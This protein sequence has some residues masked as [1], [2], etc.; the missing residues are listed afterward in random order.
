MANRRYPIKKREFAVLT[1]G[2]FLYALLYAPGV[3]IEQ[4]G[5]VSPSATAMRFLP[6]FI[7]A[8]AAL[9]LLMQKL[10]PKCFGAAKAMPT[11]E[12]PFCAWAAFLLIL[13]C[14]IP[15]FLIYYPGTFAYDTQVQAQ[16]VVCHQYSQFH[17]LAHTLFLGACLSLFGV[18]QTLEQ[19]AAV[20]SAVQMTAMAACFALACASVS[21]S[22]SRRAARICTAVFALWPY[23]M[24]FASTCTKDVLFSGFLT[25]FFALTLEY[26][27]TGGLTKPRLALMVVGGAMACLL[28]NNMIYAMLVWVALLLVFG[29]GVRRAA[30]WAL[31][32]AVLGMGAN[33]GL[34]ALTHADSGDAKE[35]LSVPAQQLSRAYTL[36]PESL[37]EADMFA[38]DTYFGDA[39]YTRYDAT[40]ADFTKNDLVTDVILE[41]KA[42]FFNLW[43]TIGARCPNIYLDALLELDLPFL[44]PY[45]AYAG[46]AKYIET[47]MTPRAL[48]MPFGGEEMSQ[49]TRFKA[50]RD[51]LDE[52]I[53]ATGA[54][55]IPVLRWVMNAG[56]AIWLMLL[57]VLY[58]MY[59][60]D[61]K[62]FGILLLPILLWGT[63]LLGPVMQGRYLYPFVC[64]LP[65]LLAVP[66]RGKGETLGTAS[67]GN[68][69]SR[70]SAPCDFRFSPR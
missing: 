54:R 11:P 25:V 29:R 5:S 37:T 32:A 24:I 26:L 17:P 18:L 68:S 41:D 44:Y 27:R 62:R 35:M 16:Q 45:R 22:C 21:R 14:Y 69:H 38:M 10:M 67:P 58:T 66:K 61:W 43:L 70:A 2:A 7:V 55:D 46:T 49:P 50:V 13:A 33:Q 51:W 6:A 15:I 1:F 23:H 57:C 28:R 39:G 4:S 63:Y 53:W 19:C 48:T 42:G 52:H 59:T 20:Y 30:C 8:W 3:Q 60:G 65:L 47:G 40:L 12:K 34:A 64:L 31:L 56:A 36:S 9:W